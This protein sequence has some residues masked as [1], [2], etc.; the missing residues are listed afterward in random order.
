MIDVMTDQAAQRCPDLFASTEAPLNLWQWTHFCLDI[1][2]SAIC[3]P[4][5]W[6]Q[7]LERLPQLTRYFKTRHRQDRVYQVA[8]AQNFLKRLLGSEAVAVPK[9]S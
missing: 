2:R 7:F 6:Q 1:I 5:S 8:V 4:L 9:L 3:G